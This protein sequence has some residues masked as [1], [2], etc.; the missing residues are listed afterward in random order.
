VTGGCHFAWL[1][2]GSST[3]STAET[4][5][6]A[7]CYTLALLFAASK[8]DLRATQVNVPVL[9]LVLNYSQQH[10]HGKLLCCSCILVLNCFL[11]TKMI[12]FCCT[13]DGSM[14]LN[15]V[16]VLVLHFCD[17]FVALNAKLFAVVLLLENIF[18]HHG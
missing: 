2:A 9:K 1:R 17:Q 6:K 7:G 16:V 3:A 5:I 4:L 8:D 10:Q 15:C 18:P 12:E 13:W 11:N 14:V